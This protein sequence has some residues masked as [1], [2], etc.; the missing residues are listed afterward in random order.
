MNTP[1][2][3]WQTE[4]ADLQ[5][6]WTSAWYS[7]GGAGEGWTWANH[8]YQ[9]IVNANASAYLYWIGVQ[10]GNTN[11]HMVCFGFYCHGV[12]F[13]TLSCVTATWLR[14]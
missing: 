1:H 3:V 14:S 8:V 2:R 11:S 4:A 7:Y 5:G 9:A 13:F 12:S 6:A 10:T